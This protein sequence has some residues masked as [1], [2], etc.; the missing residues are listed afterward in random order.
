M[1]DELLRMRRAGDGRKPEGA[2][3]DLV[4]S[5]GKAEDHVASSILLEASMDF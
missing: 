3:E 5:I 4:G 2:A 1:R